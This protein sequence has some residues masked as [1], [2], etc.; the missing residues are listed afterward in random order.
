MLTFA[1]AKQV[2]LPPTGRERP[3]ILA[4][5][6]EQHQF[7]DIAKIESHASPVRPSVFPDLVPDD[8]GLV[9]EAPCLHHGEA[10]RKHGVR[11][12][13]IKVCRIRRDV[14]YRQHLDL[15]ELHSAVAR[16]PLVLGCYFPGFVRELPRRVGENCRKPSS[17]CEVQ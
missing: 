1:R 10:L 4:A 9:L 16:Q 5:H 17:P 2:H 13:Q 12:P 15:I 3:C 8:V 7:G 11:T 14:A 6:A